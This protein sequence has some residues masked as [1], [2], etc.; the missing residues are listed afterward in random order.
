MNTIAQTPK[1]DSNSGSFLEPEMANLLQL[2]N[3]VVLK[4]RRQT[5]EIYS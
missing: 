3:D 4:I 1:F 5:Q 2:T